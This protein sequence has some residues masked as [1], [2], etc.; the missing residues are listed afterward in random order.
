MAWRPLN[1]QHAIEIARVVVA[2]S[3]VIPE[4]LQKATRQGVETRR[5]SLGF[6]PAN[7]LSGAA[8]TFQMGPGGPAPMAQPGP[9]SGWQF[10]RQ[11]VPGRNLEALELNGAELAYQAAEYGRW[12]LFSE[13]LKKVLGSVPEQ[14]GAVLSRRA[15]VLEYV[16]RFV[17]EGPPETADARDILG[18]TVSQIPEN[19]AAGQSLWHIHRGWFHN[20][21]GKSVLVNINFGTE[22]GSVDGKTVVRGLHAVTRVELRH[23]PENAEIDALF[24]DLDFLHGIAN[25]TFAASISEKAR[26]MI[27]LETGS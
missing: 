3:E 6:P 1:P 22:D 11:A 17:F 7:Q 9:V 24:G 14:L 10:L 26:A 27:G 5:E 12:A 23:T 19:A 18:D 4:K 15:T 20:Q 8:F 2:F 21:D 16:D 25:E 13:R